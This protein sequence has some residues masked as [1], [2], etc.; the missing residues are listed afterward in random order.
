VAVRRRPAREASGRHF[1]RSSQL[2]AALAAEAEVRDGGLVVEIGGGTGMLTQALARTGARVVAIER[3]RA[4]AARL[5]TRFDRHPDVSIVEAD[6]LEH[7]WPEEPFAVVSNLPFARSGAILARLLDD[8][9]SLLTR[10]HVIVQWEHAAKLAAVWPSTLRSTYWRAWYDI[11]IGRRLDRTAFAPPP[12]VDA[13]VLRFER[14]RVPRVPVASHRAYRRFLAAAF[15]A[16]EPI[17]RGLREL[18]PLQIKRLAPALGF[19]LDG[20]AWDLDAEQWACVFASA[21]QRGRPEPP[22]TSSGR[23]PGPRRG[24]R[25]TA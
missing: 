4:L 6:A 12:A 10:A 13:A 9:H 5:R 18:S 7:A 19:D 2:A 3:D 22:L 25:G 11:S 21:R 20:H 24:R 23:G 16:R 1:L 8:P 15:A 14:L 17:R